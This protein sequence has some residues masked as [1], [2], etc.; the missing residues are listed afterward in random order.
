MPTF[1][2]FTM[3]TKTPPKTLRYTTAYQFYHFKNEKATMVQIQNKFLQ[4]FRRVLEEQIPEDLEVTLAKLDFRSDNRMII[5]LQGSNKDELTFVSNIFKKEI[6][7]EIMDAHNVPKDK[8]LFGSLRSVGKV[9]FGL[10]V[11]IGIENPV[12]EVLIPL[13]QLR[14]QLT[15]GKKISTQEICKKYGFINNFPVQVEIT[16]LEYEKGGKMKFEAKFSEKYLAQLEEWASG[17]NEIIITTGSAR[18][19]VKR[20]IAKRG[21]SVDIVK[22]QR[23][24][25]LETAIICQEGTT[26]PGIVSHI[27]PFMSDC[28]MNML[29]P[30][31]LREFWE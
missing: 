14:K 24:G 7:G 9:G 13:H 1:L 21:H 6:T 22:I 10:F 23:L 26:A 16:K 17:K 31:Q 29:R 11:D 2:V 19:F 28:R 8:A 25:P 27:G 4:T 3:P 18:Q 15:A 20:T 12:K 5:E 30:S